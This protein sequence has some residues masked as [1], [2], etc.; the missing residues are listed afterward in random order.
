MGFFP[1]CLL[2]MLICASLSMKSI[3]VAYGVPPYKR[4][5]ISSMVY[6]ID[7]CIV[8]P[9]LLWIP[10]SNK[11]FR[12]HN[13]FTF[14]LLIC[15]IKNSISCFVATSELL[16]I[17]KHIPWACVWWFP[18]AYPL[19][20]NYILSVVHWWQVSDFGL[21]IANPNGSPPKNSV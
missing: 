4:R 1:L 7:L 14:V 18:W 17:V 11:C 6:Y 3:I 21:T 16:N 15:V 9:L 8:C 19:T 13:F 5:C 2:F 12:L 10:F 20:E